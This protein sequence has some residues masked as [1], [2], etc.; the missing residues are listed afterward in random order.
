MLLVVRDGVY[1]TVQ[2][3]TVAAHAG[4]AMLRM[5]LGGMCVC[6]CVCSITAIA[7]ITRSADIITVHCAVC[8][9]AHVTL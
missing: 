2:T 3:M 9:R 6:V 8:H 1:K 5:H 4:H 7:E